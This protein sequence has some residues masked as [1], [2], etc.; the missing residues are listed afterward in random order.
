MRSIHSISFGTICVATAVLA[1]VTVSIPADASIR[2]AQAAPNCVQTSGVTVLNSQMQYTNN[3]P[4]QWFGSQVACPVITDT[5]IFAGSATSAAIYGSSYVV[6][7]L[8]AAACVN[9]QGGG[10][11]SCGSYTGNSSTGNVIVQ[12]ST[13]HWTSH[14]W[15]FPYVSVIIG[16]PSGGSSNA[17]WGIA[18]AN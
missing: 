3:D 9:A 14:A 15:D 1:T 16:P 2:F 13:S 8:W 12:F 10:G 17:F 7:G 4:S 5:N 6:S 18:F 11:G